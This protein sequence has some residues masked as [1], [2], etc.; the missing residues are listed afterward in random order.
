MKQRHLDESALEKAPI[1]NHRKDTNAAFALICSK[2]QSAYHQATDKADK[3]MI[4]ELV[5]ALNHV[6][7]D[8]ATKKKSKKKQLSITQAMERE[9]VAR[10]IVPMIPAFAVSKGYDANDVVFT[11]RVL[12]INHITRY[13]LHVKSKD[14]KLWV[15]VVK[16]QL[17]ETSIA[18]KRAVAQAERRTMRITNL[19]MERTGSMAAPRSRRSLMQMKAARIRT[20]PA[21]RRSREA[22]VA[23]KAANPLGRGM[24]KSR[25]KVDVARSRLRRC[26]TTSHRCNAT[27]VVAARE[28]VMTEVPLRVVCTL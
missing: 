27:C 22:K 10:R 13:E 28:M 11:G 16:G 15:R 8:Y 17:V 3:Q 24:P 9:R 14:T 5:D 19:R 18:R 4:V 6:L 25:R 21:Q 12:N 23:E 1:S 26:I 2:I 7:A 20:S